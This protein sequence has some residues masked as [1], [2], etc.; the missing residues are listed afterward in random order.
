MDPPSPRVTLLEAVRREIRSRHLSI[1]TEQQYVYWIRWFVRFH[2]RR[3]P[4]EM[5]AAEVEAFLSMLAGER[6]AS[7]STHSQALSALLS[8]YRA[9]LKQDLPWLDKLQRPK[10]PQRLPV[11]MAPEEVAA[12]LSHLDGQHALL[13]RLLYGTGMRIMEALRL[14]VKDVDFSRN[15]LFVRS[16]KSNKDRAL[17]L[18]Q[19][20]AR[21]LR[22]Q[23]AYANS[24]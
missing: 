9:V 10:R 21:E 12:A 11:V 5:R 13:G 24:L 1:R 3:H 6:H 8:L 7:P 16:G 4:R 17:M 14:R 15:T 20:L 22:A 2:R 18:P 19:A 23:L